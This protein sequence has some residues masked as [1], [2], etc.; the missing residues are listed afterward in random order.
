M[1]SF[2]KFQI[3]LGLLGYC[4][5]LAV[6]ALPPAPPGPY[7][8]LEDDLLKVK[9]PTQAGVVQP[10][11][12]VRAHDWNWGAPSVP[13]NPVPRTPAGSAAPNPADVTK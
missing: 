3:I 12:D 8:S 4:F 2:T 7:V 13:V 6:M 10:N 5:G 11:S 1:R 9:Q